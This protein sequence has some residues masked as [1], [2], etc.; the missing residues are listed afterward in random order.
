M[1]DVFP[2]VY[3]TETL[4]SGF[5]V[6]L[7]AIKVTL[8]RSPPKDHFSCWLTNQQNAKWSNGRQQVWSGFTMT[9]NT[10][11]M[12][13]IEDGRFLTTLGKCIPQ[14]TTAIIAVGKIVLFYPC[15]LFNYLE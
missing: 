11:I 7:M 12:Q 9:Q 2:A 1:V 10:M 14:Y 15:V 4:R 8:Y 3:T 5:A 6:E 13:T